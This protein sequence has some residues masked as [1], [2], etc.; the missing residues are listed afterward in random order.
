LAQDNLT[1]QDIAYLRVLKPGPAEVPRPARPQYRTSAAAPVRT[2]ADAARRA[3][4]ALFVAGLALAIIGGVI[5]GA[6]LPQDNS[7]DYLGDST[8]SG[9]AAGFAIGLLVTLA[10]WLCLTISVI[11]KGVAL[12][13]RSARR[14]DQ[15][16]I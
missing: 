8:S 3:V 5:A 4:V 9:S 11:A 16:G 7:T 14:S 1:E 15:R 13:V 10:G 12:G 6:S 2:D